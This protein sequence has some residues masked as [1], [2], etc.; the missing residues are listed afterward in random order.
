MQ[1]LQYSRRALARAAPFGQQSRNM[2]AHGSYE[3]NIKAMKFWTYCSFLAL[4]P[5]AAFGFYT[6][7]HGHHHDHEAP[8]YPYMKKRDKKFPW[9]SSCDLFD[10]SCMAK[11]A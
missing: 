10:F 9:G 6:M 8:A 5:V 7:S 11:G 1:V 3:D 4:P 2:S